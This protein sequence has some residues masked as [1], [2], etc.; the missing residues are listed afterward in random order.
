MAKLE[1]VSLANSIQSFRI[2]IT[3]AH[4]LVPPSPPNSPQTELY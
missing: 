2:R 1:D 4:E 3:R